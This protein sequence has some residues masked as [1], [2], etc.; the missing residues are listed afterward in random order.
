MDKN[1]KDKLSR[2]GKL[3]CDFIQ[4]KT[5]DDILI[6]YFQN[7]Q[8]IFNP[9]SNFTEKILKK[10][11][12]MEMTIGSLS[13]EEKDLLNL[14]LDRNETFR[15]CQIELGHSGQYT[16]DEY[17]IISGDY[18]QPNSYN[19]KEYNTID[20]IFKITETIY[21]SGG[22]PFSTTLDVSGEEIDDFIEDIGE[23]AFFSVNKLKQQI[24]KFIEVC[25]LIEKTKHVTNRF[26]EIEDIAR[27][28]PRVLNLHKN[29]KEKQEK[30]KSILLQIIKFD[31][32]YQFKEFH[33]ILS[34][35]NNANAVK[36]TVSEENMFIKKGFTENYFFE[37]KFEFDDVF[38][39]PISYC[40]IEYLKHPEYQG[41]ERLAVCQFCN[42]IFS[43]SRLNDRQRFCP[44]CSPKNKM[45]K[46]QLANY[47]KAYIANPARKKI[48]AKK[49]REAEIQK[50][51]INT[52]RT[53]KEVEES[54]DD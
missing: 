18:T 9:S 25:R 33:S 50:H 40:L 19:L 20:F 30:L 4:D 6:S 22:E 32:Y 16:L 41:R 5:T 39:L 35:Y 44:V 24:N 15:S 26:E 42:C 11:P 27:F 45:T 46:E 7:L 2:Y 51:I 10:H 38:N 17:E 3:I 31:K 1:E 29:I 14:L 48:V 36:I 53:R 12:T 49:K 43:K 34:E 8:S 37:K 21:G 52:G 13:P 54:M 23:S 28:Y 47:H